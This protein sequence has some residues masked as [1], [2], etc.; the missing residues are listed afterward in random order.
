MVTWEYYRDRWPGA[1]I[2]MEQFSAFA[3][4]AQ[5]MLAYLGQVYR[6]EQRCDDATQ[7]GLCALAQTLYSMGDERIEQKS[8]GNVSV[9]YARGKSQL[10]ALRDAILPYFKIYRGVKDGL[11]W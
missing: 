2:P 11:P 4:K 3:L 1:V 9:R 10:H 8:V 5:Q 6:L 7:M